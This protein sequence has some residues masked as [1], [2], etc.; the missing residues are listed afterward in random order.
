MTARVPRPHFGQIIR[1]RRLGRCFSA[2]LYFEVGVE[3]PAEFIQP[4][5][6]LT[7]R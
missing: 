5:S 6:L 4:G 7:V 2:A 1:E 3:E